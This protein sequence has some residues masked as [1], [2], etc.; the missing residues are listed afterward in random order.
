MLGSIYQIMCAGNR[1]HFEKRDCYVENVNTGRRTRIEEKG[2]TFEV[3]IWVPKQ[4]ERPVNRQPLNQR[5]AAFQGL[6]ARL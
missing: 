5:P 6:D 1:V 4:R 3:G 2:G